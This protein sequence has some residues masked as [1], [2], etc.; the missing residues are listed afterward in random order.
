MHGR[1]GNQVEYEANLKLSL[2][3]C[4]KLGGNSDNFY[5][6]ANTYNLLGNVYDDKGDYKLSEEYY[7]KALRI[8]IGLHGEKYFFVALLYNNLG[9]IYSK[10]NNLPKTE[11]YYLKSLKIKLELFGENHSNYLFE[12]FELVG[13]LALV[14]LKVQVVG[15]R[16]QCFDW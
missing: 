16:E 4:K 11:E 3:K 10:M 8:Q 2:E 6:F 13:S 7:Q 14:C 12:L 15:Q 1:L 5:Y 9:I